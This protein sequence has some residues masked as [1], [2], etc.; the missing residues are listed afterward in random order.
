MRLSMIGDQC[1]DY[2]Q[3]RRYQL[4]SVIPSR[5]DASLKNQL[6]QVCRMSHGLSAR[7]TE[8]PMLLAP[9]KTLDK[10]RGRRNKRHGTTAHCCAAHRVN[11]QYNTSRRALTH[12]LAS[13]FTPVFNVVLVM[14]P[15]IRN[16]GPGDGGRAI[17]RRGTVIS[18]MLILFELDH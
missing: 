12:C 8:E 4:T 15:S 5:D 7:N 16:Q 14:V 3:E 17:R 2:L 10:M 6:F 18:M 13:N 9:R 11:G 1:T